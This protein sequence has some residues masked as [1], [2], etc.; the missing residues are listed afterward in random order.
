MVHGHGFI[1]KGY[2]ENPLYTSEYN[3]FSKDL[4]KGAKKPL[5][6]LRIVKNN[7]SASNLRDREKPDRRPHAYDSQLDFLNGNQVKK[8]R[9]FYQTFS[10]IK[11]FLENFSVKSLPVYVVNS[12]LLLWLTI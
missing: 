11:K 8:T 5:V 7:S 6:F 12:S 3:F 4:V 2:Q 10:S 9:R 1:Q